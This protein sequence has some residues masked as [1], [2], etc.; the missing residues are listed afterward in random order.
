MRKQKLMT[1]ELQTATANPLSLFLAKRDSIPSAI[2]FR[3]GIERGLMFDVGNVQTAQLPC[4]T[5][6]ADEKEK[7]KKICIAG[8]SITVETVL[9]PQT[10]MIVREKYDGPFPK[11]RIECTNL[12]DA[13]SASP[14]A[15]RWYSELSPIAKVFHYQEV[16]Q[17]TIITNE[18]VLC[19][20]A[21]PYFDKKDVCKEKYLLLGNVIAEN[22]RTFGQIVVPKASV[23]ALNGSI[24][25]IRQHF[26]SFK[27]IPLPVRFKINTTDKMV[28]SFHDFQIWEGGHFN[29][30]K[31]QEVN[32]LVYWDPEEYISTDDLIR[33]AKS[34]EVQAIV[35]ETA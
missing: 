24:G 4:F 10:M 26:S 16:G 15:C 8:K 23:K 25:N 1:Q 3:E 18:E 20:N 29:L 21:C 34:R 28:M 19:N 5:V 11:G 2:S 14:N 13:L 17:Q 35:Q 33:A 22:V 7:G 32:G 6:K 30:I 12:G 27:G 9:S 31:S